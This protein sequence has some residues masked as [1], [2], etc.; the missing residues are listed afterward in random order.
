MLHET[1]QLL[2][3]RKRVEDGLSGCGLRQPAI[4]HFHEQRMQLVKQYGRT[5]LPQRM[6]LCDRQVLLAR[7]A[8]E[9]KQGIHQRDNA[10]R[11]AVLGIDLDCF[12]KLPPRV[13]KTARMSDALGS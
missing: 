7:L 8:I 6:A 1:R 12:D 3:A 5:L 11:V 4:L 10:R 2:P 13:T 9:G